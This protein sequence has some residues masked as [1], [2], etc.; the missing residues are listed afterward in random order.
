MASPE[1]LTPLLPETLP[2]DF[3]EWDGEA[4]PEA[5]PAQPGEWEAWEA[6]HSFGEPKSPHGQS[7]DLHSA[8][9][10]PP[11]EKPR[12]TDPAAT[13]PAVAAPQ[14]HFVEWE[15]ETSPTPKPVDLSEW[16]AWEAAHGF[17]TNPNPAKPSVDREASSSTVAERPRAASTIPPAPAPAKPELKSKPSNGFHGANGHA[18]YRPEASSSTNGAAG[19][20]ELPKRAAINGKPA[21]PEPATVSPRLDDRA[22]FE[23]FAEKSVEAQAKPKAARKK[24]MIVAP[25]SASA[26]LLVGALMFPLLHHGAKPGIKTNVQPPA[27]TT[28]TQQETDPSNAPDGAPGA[29]TQPAST[30]GKQPAAGAPV[31]NGQ[32]EVKPAPGLTKTQTKM[33]DDQLTAP[34]VIPQTAGKLAENAPP[35]VNFGS[36]GAD[37]LGGTGTSDSLLGEHTQT[38]VKVVSSRPYAISSGVATG[39]LIRQTPP[40]YPAIAKAARVSGTVVLHATIA[41]NGT[42]KDLQ[43]V[44]GS[45]MLQQAALDAVRS[46]R[47]RPYKLSNE[48]IEVETT[49]SVVFSL[50]K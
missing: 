37:G 46:W 42:I 29:Q 47:Y 8:P 31:S 27:Q 20:L 24:W 15:A 5:S 2:E 34:T 10:A 11:T 1:E 39:M 22:L 25:V 23:A 41:K 48:P 13:A 17:G 33:M 21:S 49:I 12:A 4:S 9:A 35:P 7:V 44:S 3:G 28:D 16:E 40:V 18:S 14:K 43:V 26:V 38:A 6:T 50:S 45:P 19:T 30:T 32:D 36:G